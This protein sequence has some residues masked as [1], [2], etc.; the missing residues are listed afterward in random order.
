MWVQAVR[1]GDG[2]RGGHEADVSAEEPEGQAKA[3]VSQARVECRRPEGPCAEARQRQEARGR[4]VGERVGA[5]RRGGDRKG[6][7]RGAL[8]GLLRGGE[9]VRSPCFRRYRVGVGPPGVGFLAGKKVGGAVRRN[10][11]KRVLREAFRASDVNLAGIETLVFIATERTGAV[12][13][14]ELKRAMVAALREVSGRA[15]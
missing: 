5:K 8:E 14:A 3:R 15:G 1:W 13:F 6:K 10:R 9:V 11:A 4:S 7:G 2:R 12:P